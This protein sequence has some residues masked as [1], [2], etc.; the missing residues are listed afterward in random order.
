MISHKPPRIITD[1]TDNV[2]S[3]SFSGHGMKELGVLISTFDNFLG[4]S[5]H[6]VDFL[7]VKQVLK[8]GLDDSLENDLMRGKKSDLLQPIEE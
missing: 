2:I 5:L 3:I 1:L 7:H 4:V 8:M 6:L